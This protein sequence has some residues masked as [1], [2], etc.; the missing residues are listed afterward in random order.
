MLKFIYGTMGA[1]KSLDLIRFKD[2]LE[3]HG[4]NF[5][6]VTL[7]KNGIIS[8]R[9]S[10]LEHEA[11]YTSI[12]LELTEYEY[13]L[14]DEAQFMR[15]SDLSMIYNLSRNN[16]K[17]I[18]CYGLLKD[19]KGSIFQASSELLAIADSLQEV[20]S[21]C[22]YCCNAKASHHIKIE[23]DSDDD[24]EKSIYKSICYNCFLKE[25]NKEND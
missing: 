18:Y 10:E 12:T 13:I 25:K 24:L 11:D 8:S 6:I 4:V 16:N 21:V 1:G 5:A 19:Y 22:D 23:H 17:K 15:E 3:R 14:I 7:N 20:S 9:F 2:T